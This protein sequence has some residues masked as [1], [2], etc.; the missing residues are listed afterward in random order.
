MSMTMQAPPEPGACVY[1]IGVELFRQGHALAEVFF[2][3]RGTVKL[4]QVDRKGRESLIG[5]ETS[6]A[7]IGSAAVIADRPTPTSA[8]TCTPA[9]IRRCSA[10]AFRKL[11][12][13]DPQLSINIHEAH[14]RELCQQSTRIAQLCS[15]DSRSRLRSALARF[16][17]AAVPFGD[18][19]A[20]KM[21][22][23][24]R[25]WELAEFIGVRP[26][27]L[28]RLLRD[29]E[30]DGLIRRAKGWIIVGDVERLADDDGA[31]NVG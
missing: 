20:V 15:S 8:V 29:L 27:H 5:L 26:E 2:I 31:E 11:L 14:A 1:P 6:P 23:P 18:G 19:Q 25:R 22:L 12:H 24:F 10:K 16:A 4:T 13:E 17:A 28:S 7:W 21:Q 9:L 30:G 3:V